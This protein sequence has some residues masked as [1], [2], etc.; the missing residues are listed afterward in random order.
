MYEALSYQYMRPEAGEK[1]KIQLFISLQPSRDLSS[2]GMG[3]K[4]VLVAAIYQLLG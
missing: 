2:L 3:V 4:G 1:K